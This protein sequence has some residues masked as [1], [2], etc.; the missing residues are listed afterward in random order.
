MQTPQIITHPLDRSIA[1]A[2]FVTIFFTI[3]ALV[4]GLPVVLILTILLPI[5]I[6]CK[7]LSSCYYFHTSGTS[8][9]TSRIQGANLLASPSSPSAGA[10]SSGGLSSV[11]R[12]P[13]SSSR[14]RRRKLIPLT[15]L[16]SFHL[17]S[18]IKNNSRFGVCNILMLFDKSLNLDQLK[19][20]ITS[21]ILR[22]VEFSRFTC[23]IVFR[24]EFVLSEF[25]LLSTFSCCRSRFPNF[26]P[27]FPVPRISYVLNLPCLSVLSNHNFYTKFML[28]VLRILSVIC[29]W[30][31]KHMFFL[32]LSLYFQIIAVR[33]QLGLYMSL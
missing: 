2:F 11:P 5:G 30:K 7:N 4:S 23:E 20:I 8:S 21:R 22:K 31:C 1:M 32:S 17:C 3:L 15:A 33:E 10:S 29:F 19:D 28:P 16:E 24:G 25:L 6:L 9:W 18:S 12:P 14:R 27:L 26:A 13:S